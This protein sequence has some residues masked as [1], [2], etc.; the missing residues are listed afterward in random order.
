LTHSDYLPFLIAALQEIYLM[1]SS[2]RNR[3]SRL[4]ASPSAFAIVRLRDAAHD[5]HPTRKACGDPVA[6]RQRRDLLISK[7]VNVCIAG[8]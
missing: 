5:G 4:I 2:A 7:V 3:G 8:G 1:T 6:Q